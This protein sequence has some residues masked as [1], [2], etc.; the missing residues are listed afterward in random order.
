M[1]RKEPACNLTEDQ[2]KDIV[3]DVLIDIL[4]IDKSKIVE[5]AYLTRD[6]GMDSFTA[7][8]VLVTIE[9]KLGISLA[10]VKLYTVGDLYNL[11]LKKWNAL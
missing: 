11:V 4:R 6:I 5:S 3:K 1:K 9:D 8:V 10:S 2:V 7:Q